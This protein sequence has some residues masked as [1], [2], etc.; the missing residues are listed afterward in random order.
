MAIKDLFT[1]FK[2]RISRKSFWLGSLVVLIVQLLAIFLIAK[3][4]GYQAFPM[5]GE[6]DP[7][8]YM[9]IHR[10]FSI[11]SALAT[12]LVAWPSTAVLLKRLHDRNRS[13]AWLLFYWVPSICYSLINLADL[14]MHP[15]ALSNGHIIGFP[16]PLGG[17]A[18]L[19]SLAVS[20]FGLIDMG[21]LKG[22]EGP[23][24]FGD[25]PLENRN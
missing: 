21:L 4:L 7:A 2:G 5:P 23:N 11:T 13:I 20:V 15:V 25:D 14:G 6:T 1:G 24:Q 12:L 3:I 8:A 22:T 10:Q 16:T 18:L 17:I 19:A 9:T